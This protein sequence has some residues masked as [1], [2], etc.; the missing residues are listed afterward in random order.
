MFTIDPVGM[1]STY[2]RSILISCTY[3]YHSHV[4][5]TSLVGEGGKV[6]S[7][8]DTFIRIHSLLSLEE[9]NTVT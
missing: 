4:N 9:I 3:I 6:L 2:S 8:L 1:E 5:R 7:Q